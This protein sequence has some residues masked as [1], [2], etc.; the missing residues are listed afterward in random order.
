MLFV[1]TL[2]DR[3]AVYDLFSSVLVKPSPNFLSGLEQSI[4]L[5][6][7]CVFFPP[8]ARPLLFNRLP[9][10]LTGEFDRIDTLEDFLNLG[11]GLRGLG[12]LESLLQ[13]PS[14][15]V[16][17]CFVSSCLSSPAPDSLMLSQA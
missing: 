11:L 14:M 4:P 13:T 9:V 1:I 8:L 17:V 2:V 3:S 16:D 10:P 5:L 6:S 7:H 15:A 12:R